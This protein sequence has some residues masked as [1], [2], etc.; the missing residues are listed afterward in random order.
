MHGACAGEDPELFF[1]VG[2]NAAAREQADEA[3]AVC[4]RCPVMEICG[5]WALEHRI[6]SGVWGALTEDDR[7]AIL[8]RRGRGTG[9]GRKA[10]AL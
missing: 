1:P 6:E 2:N 3:K 8:R 10:R 5:Q 4:Y 9:R 7:R